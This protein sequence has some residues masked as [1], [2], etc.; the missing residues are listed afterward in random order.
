VRHS[1]TQGIRLGPSCSGPSYRR[2]RGTRAWTGA[3]AVRGTEGVVARGLGLEQLNVGRVLEQRAR[4]VTTTIP[5]VARCQHTRYENRYRLRIRLLPFL[6]LVKIPI[7]SFELCRCRLLRLQSSDCLVHF[8]RL[9]AV[10]CPS[11]QVHETI[12]FLLVT[13]PNIHRLKK[14]FTDSAINLS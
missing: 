12:T 11:A 1:T 6:K 4:L 10:C 9:L 3:A 5:Q 13:L 2:S 7:C 14:S 8:L